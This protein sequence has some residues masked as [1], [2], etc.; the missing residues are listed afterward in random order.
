[1]YICTVITIV[2]TISIVTV[3]IIITITIT[4]VTIVT[5][6]T[7]PIPIVIVRRLLVVLRVRIGRHQLWYFT[8][9]WSDFGQRFV[10]FVVNKMTS[11]AIAAGA[12]SLKVGT[13]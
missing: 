13:I 6:I 10:R 12:V 2:I 3:S 11:V 8:G 5:I 1:M 9:C 4:V 7:I